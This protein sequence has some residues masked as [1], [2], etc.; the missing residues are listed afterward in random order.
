[1]SRPT[2]VVGYCH[3]LQVD[4]LFHDSLVKLLMAE[5]RRIKDVFSAESGPFLVP[6]RN[7]VAQAFMASGAD[8]LLQLDA[9]M[10]FEPDLLSRLLAVGTP[11]RL[12]SGLY[13]A[14]DRTGSTWPLLWDADLRPIRQYPPNALVPVGG[15]GGG[16]LLI[17]RNHLTRLGSPYFRQEPTGQYDQD[18]TFAHDLAKVGIPT[19][20]HTGIQ[21]GH[22]KR[23]VVT[24]ATYRATLGGRI[25]P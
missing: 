20:V 12:V 14:H 9:D 21:L 25:E 22:A 17:H 11:G 23:L 19:F 1:M 6:A 16:C 24:E 8:W 13:F 4:A 7:A 2:V 15:V 5:G 18:Q 3:G 10:V